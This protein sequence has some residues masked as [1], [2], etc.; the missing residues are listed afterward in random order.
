MKLGR[1]GRLWGGM[2]VWGRFVDWS[3]GA[4]QFGGIVKEVHGVGFSSGVFWF[5][6]WGGVMGSES[7]GWKSWG[8]SRGLGSRGGG[9]TELQVM[10]WGYGAGLGYAVESRVRNSRV[11]EQSHG[12]LGK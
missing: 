1:A 3:Y 4:M 11:M 8:C 9:I 12:G 10:E 6:L 7:W 5:G 2:Q